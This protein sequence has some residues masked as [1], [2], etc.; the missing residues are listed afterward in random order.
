MI[1]L[2]GSPAKANPD[3]LS[4]SQDTSFQF[5]P[6]APS[7]IKKHQRVILKSSGVLL[8]TGLFITAYNRYDRPVHFLSQQNRSPFTDNSAKVLQPLGTAVPIHATFA[9]LFAVGAFAKRPKMKEAAVVGL[10]SFYLNALLTDKLKKS[11]QRHRPSNTNDSH[12]FEGA[13]GDGKNTSFPSS[14][15]S[16][17]FAAATAIASVYHDHRWIPQAAYGVATLVGLSR[18]NDNKHWASDVLAGAAVGYLTGK[19]TYWGYHRIKKGITRKSWIV[20]PVWQN[21]QTGVAAALQF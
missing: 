1:T 5:T 8:A 16:N 15:T 13:N 17:A 3:T 20:T 14:H 11:F 19:A 4:V 7:W 10:S 2:P 18:I 9:T 12:L 21:G 6:P